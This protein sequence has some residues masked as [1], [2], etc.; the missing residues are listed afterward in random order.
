MAQ[1]KNPASDQ[2]ENRSASLSEIK[3]SPLVTDQGVT[4]VEETV[5][6]KLAGLAAR[7]VPGVHA[8]GNAARRTFDA[9]TERIPGSQTH[10]GG[11]VSVQRGETETAID[12]TVIV[13]YGAAVVEVSDAIRHNVTR[14]VQHGTGLD[15]VEVNIT[16]TDVHLPEDD[17]DE[18][19]N[20][21]A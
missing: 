7:E 13:E 6:Q 20:N 19:E 8:L 21:L 10:V 16:V 3:N 11:G 14:A 15:V 12:L 2:N 9:I 1:T 5:I 17:D 4:T 18:S